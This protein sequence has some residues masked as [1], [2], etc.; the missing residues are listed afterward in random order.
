MPRQ[1]SPDARK[2]AREYYMSG[3]T[4]DEIARKMRG[5]DYPYIN[6]ETVRRWAD[7][8]GWAE[9]REK[10]QAEEGRAALALD[11]ER[12]TA[13]MLESYSKM[14]L[15]AQAYLSDGK[16]EFA[17]GVNLILK[18]DA[19]RRQL[20]NQVANRQS[21]SIDKP[22]MWLEFMADL[23][24]DLAELDPGALEALEP[25]MEAIKERAKARFAEA[26]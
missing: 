19:L 18:I 6:A 11:A 5:E 15:D 3:L 23:I 13:E 20:L 7:K 21:A 16:L 12:A 2:R 9:A 24:N 1:Y 14:R 10:L 22:A 8:G 26:A 25:H 4:F 17:D